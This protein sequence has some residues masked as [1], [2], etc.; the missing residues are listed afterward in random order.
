MPTSSLFAEPSSLSFFPFCIW[1][2]AYDV[3]LPV[4][5]D[6]MAGSIL[7][8][9]TNRYRCGVC[10]WWIGKFILDI[11]SLFINWF[12]PILNQSYYSLSFLH[13][14]CTHIFCLMLCDDF[15]HVFIPSCLSRNPSNTSVST[16]YYRLVTSDGVGLSGWRQSW[17]S[18]LLF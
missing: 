5:E 11:S 1:V 8:V 13:L 3:L 7:H 4:T 16:F 9:Y 18:L 10:L 6:S 14:K 15:Y 12:F 17:C 2:V